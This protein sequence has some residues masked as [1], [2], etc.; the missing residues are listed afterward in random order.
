MSSAIFV[1]DV[2]GRVVVYRNQADAEGSLE[3]IDIHDGEYPIAYTETGEALTVEA[4][5]DN[6][7]LTPTGRSDL[8]DLQSRLRGWRY[9]PHHLGDDPHAYAQHE[10]QKVEPGAKSNRHPGAN[11]T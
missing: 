11:S 4:H 6:G 9:G 10:L 3:A 7:R 8:A 2:D 1:I 5:L